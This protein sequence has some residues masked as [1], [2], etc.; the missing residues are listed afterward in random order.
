MKILV[1]DD[2]KEI[3]MMLRDVLEAQDY[4]VLTAESGAAG[5]EAYRE[6]RPSFTLT[7][8]AMPG[9]NGLELL[10]QIKT[11]NP[12]ASVILMTGAGTEAYAIDALRGGAINYFNKPIDI[13]DLVET[14]GRYAVLAAGYDYEAY[15]ADFFESETVRLALT[16]SL[17]QVNHAVQM[18]V[19]RCRAIFPLEDIYALRFGLYEMLVNSI[20]HGNL[21]ISYEEKTRALE[22]NRLN[23]LIAERAEDPARACRRVRI[24]CELRSEEMECVIADEGNG[25]DHSVY[26]R[27]TDPAQLFEELGTSL[28]GRGIMLTCL[29]FD[30]VEFNDTG[31]EVTIVKRVRKLAKT[32]A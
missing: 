16:N 8:I 24:R 26:S 28:H 10:K 3:R 7:D 20:E 21:G 4:E 15:A 11:L 14:L 17:S 27:A 1:V 22:T 29:Q 9:M 13:N 5:L 12:E 30:K 31:N 18:I 6:H 19:N 23:A 2:Q 32:P 25:F